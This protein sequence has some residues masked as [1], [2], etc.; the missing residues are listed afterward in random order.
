[1][2]AAGAKN[3]TTRVFAVRLRHFRRY[4]RLKPRCK[5]GYGLVMQWSET[6]ESVG[7]RRRAIVAIYDAAAPSEAMLAGLDHLA[8]FSLPV[9]AVNAA[10]ARRPR[11]RLTDECFKAYPRI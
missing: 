1:V 7:R 6:N 4:Q 5:R 8:F 3:Q 10:R 9:S 2:L 11:S